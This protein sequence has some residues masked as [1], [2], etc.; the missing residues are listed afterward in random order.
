MRI[1]D[2]GLVTNESK[3][4]HSTLH[5]YWQWFDHLNQW[6]VS[7]YS[8]VNQFSFRLVVQ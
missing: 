8:Y 6:Q 7:Q 5:N 1:N 4:Q 2:V 3:G